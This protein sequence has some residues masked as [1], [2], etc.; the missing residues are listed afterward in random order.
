[1]GEFEGAKPPQNMQGV[2]G[3]QPPRY[4]GVW[5]AEGPPEIYSG[6]GGGGGAKP[7]PPLSGREG[8]P[9]S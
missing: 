2:W 4:R 5:G 8:S 3:A 1:M 9:V 6:G 7:P